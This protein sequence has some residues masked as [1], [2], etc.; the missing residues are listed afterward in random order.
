MTEATP[1]E[2]AS[3]GSTQ[4]PIRGGYR[5]LAAGLVLIVTVAAVI[6]SVMLLTE[7]SHEADD[8]RRL[9]QS[10]RTSL[11]QWWTEARPDVAALQAVLDES[12]SALHRGDAQA[13]ASACQVMHDVAAVRVPAHLPGPE[14]ELGA[15]LGAAA[16]DAHSAAHMC[17]AVIERTSNNYDA[18]FVSDLEQAGRQVKQAM[19]TVNDYLSGIP[20]AATTSAGPR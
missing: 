9:D 1:P 18:E 10:R 19:S 3:G 7:K 4:R 12:Q 6:L 8:A 2:P 15:Q 11:A 14:K 17:L 13:L 5:I 20:I 16:A